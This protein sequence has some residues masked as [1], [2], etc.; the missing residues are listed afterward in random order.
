MGDLNCTPEDAAL[1]KLRAEFSDAG[2]GIS[3]KVGTFNNFERAANPKAPRI[4][5]VFY[6]LKNLGFH[7]YKVGNTDVAEPLLSDHFPVVVEF[8]KMSSK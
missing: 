5:Y 1:K 7:S 4:D 8:E 3:S 6:K 2:I